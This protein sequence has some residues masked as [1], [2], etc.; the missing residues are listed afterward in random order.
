MTARAAAALALAFTVAACGGS[1]LHLPDG[2]PGDAADA[3]SPDEGADR[4]CVP[5]SNPSICAPILRCAPCGGD[6]GA[7]ACGAITNLAGCD[8]EGTT[9]TAQGSGV[10]DG[11]TCTCSGG[12]WLCD[13]PVGVACPDLGATCV[14]LVNYGGG[15]ADTFMCCS[16]PTHTWQRSCLLP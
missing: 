9:C 5:T 4:T 6:A 14:R 7:G 13:Y 10:C 12:F 16:G 3:A 2:S 15:G 1:P 8:Q 11:Q